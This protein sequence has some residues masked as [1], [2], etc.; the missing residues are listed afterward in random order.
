MS[1]HQGCWSRSRSRSRSRE[2]CRFRRNFTLDL[3]LDFSKIHFSISISIFRKIEIESEI[4]PK[5][6]NLARSRLRKFHW[7]ILNFRNNFL[8]DRTQSNDGTKSRLSTKL[9][10]YSFANQWAN[11]RRIRTRASSFLYTIYTDH[12][13]HANSMRAQVVQCSVKIIRQLCKQH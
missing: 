6:A 1:W 9:T 2:I 10:A 13:L 5:S 12:M 7:K 3:D 8:V 4:L 11:H